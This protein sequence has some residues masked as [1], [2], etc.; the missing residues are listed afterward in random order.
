MTHINVDKIN[1]YVSLEYMSILF[2]K[3]IDL[4]RADD[5]DS[6]SVSFR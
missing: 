1:E 3:N 5:N 6:E 4:P 2:I